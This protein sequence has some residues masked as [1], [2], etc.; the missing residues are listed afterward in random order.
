MNTSSSYNG[1]YTFK[2]VAVG[3]RERS[4]TTTVLCYHG[5]PTFTGWF[6]YIQDKITCQ[7]QLTNEINKSLLVAIYWETKV[8]RDTQPF[9]QGSVFCTFKWNT[10][11]ES[12]CYRSAHVF[13]LVYCES[14]SCIIGTNLFQM[15]KRNESAWC[16]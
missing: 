5:L 10:H 7:F 9:Y 4:S 8:C 3:F 13:P 11:I 14:I 12:L 1:H 2:L 15:Y 6:K 16:E